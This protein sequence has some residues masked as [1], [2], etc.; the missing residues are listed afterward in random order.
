MS[1]AAPIKVF[2]V[3]IGSTSME[4]HITGACYWNEKAAKDEV[5]RLHDANS[6]TRA[7]YIARQLPWPTL[8]EMEG[9][10]WL[11]PACARLAGKTKAVFRQL[12]NQHTAWSDTKIERVL[13]DW[14]GD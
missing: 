6:H 5:K 14:F 13:E 7:Y 10:Q 1:E 11:E 3:N 9:Q 8:F 2:I 12:L 4:G